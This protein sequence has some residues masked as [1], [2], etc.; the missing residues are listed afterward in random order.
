MRAHTL[1][2]FCLFV[3]CLFYLMLAGDD[4]DIL[5]QS[6]V[7]PLDIRWTM[8]VSEENTPY[9]YFSDWV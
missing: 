9:V 4:V 1:A 8:Q 2:Y 6:F 7:D 3:V 5:L